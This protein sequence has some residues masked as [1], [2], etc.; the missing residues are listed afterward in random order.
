MNV[1]SLFNGSIPLIA[2]Q[3]SAFKQGDEI[4]LAFTK[5]LDRINLASDEEEQYEITDR[6]FWEAHSSP[7]ML[8]EV[9]KIFESMK[10]DF[11]SGYEL[12][13]NKFYIG[14]AKDGSAKNFLMFRPKKNWLYITYKGNEDTESLKKAE[15]LGLDLT[16]KG[17]WKEYYLK[18]ENYNN[19]QKHKA[20][21]DELIKGSMDYFNLL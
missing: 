19:Y 4:S 21:I 16:Y 5:V 8:G 10:K 13:Y 3:M 11:I 7:K 1:I 14:M 9:D 17:A 18:L 15:A 6:R 2:L 20:F 12:K